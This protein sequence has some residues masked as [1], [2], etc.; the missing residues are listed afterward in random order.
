MNYFEWFGLPV[1][2]LTEETELRQRFYRKSKSLHPDFHTRADEDTQQEAL[3]QSS[4]NNEAY[5]VLSDPDRC[6][7]YVLGLYNVLAEEGQN[8]LPG[9]FLMEMM[10]INESLMEL[11]FDF[12]AHAL[13]RI[14][15]STTQTESA[16]YQ[17]ILPLL[18]GFDP[19]MPET[20]QLEKIKD[21]YLKKR[22][23]LRI[24]ENLSTFA[25]RQQ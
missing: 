4:F 18:K 2:F 22:Y 5:R 14:Q 12:D 16:L 1:A 15:E 9:A 19:L 17:E 3:A 24:K 10:E 23:L 6:M 25:H 21:Y 20:G 13:Q 8:Q 7:Q 11:E